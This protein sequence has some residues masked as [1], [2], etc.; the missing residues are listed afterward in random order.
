MTKRFRV[1]ATLCALLV[2]FST[3]AQVGF[4]LPF[5]NDAQPGETIILP[6]QVINFDSISSVQ[7]AI[8]WDPQVL[9]FERYILGGN[10]MFLDSTRFNTSEAATGF[11]RFNWYGSFRTLINGTS[12][13]RLEFKVIGA[14]GTS[15]PVTFT[16]ILS[17]PAI[18]FEVVQ[19]QNN[20]T[21][22]FSPNN[23]TP[24]LTH[25]FVAVGFT[26]G[27]DEPR[28]DNIEVQVTPN[29]FS[30]SATVT[31]SLE[32][33]AQ[34]QLKITDAAGKVCYEQQKFFAA[35]KN[36]M[37]I[38]KTMLRD[39]GVYFLSLTT[40]TAYSVQPIVFQ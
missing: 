22:G 30:N 10:P 20:T 3:F 28:Q 19:G 31:F 8:Q 35:G 26:A 5:V 21:Y 9:Q 24:L 4:K 11:M 1:L 38:E 12:I 18:Y 7:F 17:P 15:S 16:E 2:Y 23:Q 33:G 13:F 6:V 32:K 40:E 25:G 14:V 27:N 29:P 37:V 34:I 39:R 36:G